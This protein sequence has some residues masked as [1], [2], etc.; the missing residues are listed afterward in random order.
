MYIVVLC[1]FANKLIFNV[2]CA[3]VISAVYLVRSTRLAGSMQG[4]WNEDEGV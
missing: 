4:I 1:I 2:F 3:H